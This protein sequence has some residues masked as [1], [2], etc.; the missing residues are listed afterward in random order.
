MSAALSIHDAGPPPPCPAP[1]NLVQHVLAAGRS[2]PDKPALEILSPTHATTLTHGELAR[3]VL[4][5]AGGLQALG[6][7]LGLEGG[8]RILLRIGNHVEFPLVFLGAIA[9]GFVPVPTPAQLT[10]PEVAALCRA[11]DPALTVFGPGCDLLDD[12]PCPVLP[13]ERTAELQ[14]H[15]PVAPVMGDPERPAY[16]IST[17]GTAGRPRLLAHAHR[18]VW[19]R[20]MMWQGWYGL[21]PGDRMFHAGGFNWTYTLGTGLMDPWAV[22]ATAV[23]PAPGLDRVA[24]RRLLKEAQATILAATP[25]VYRQLLDG[26]TRLPLPTLRHGLTAGEKMPPRLARR[27]QEAT[28][29]PLYEA[30]GMSECST[31]VSAHPGRPA[32]EGAIGWPQPGRRVAVLGADRR[33]VPRGTSGILAVSTRDPGLMLGYLDGPESAP[34]IPE[35]MLVPDP[36]TGGRW[37]L[38]G[39]MVEMAEDG[40]ITYLGRQDDMLNAGGFRVSPLEV[41]A[42]LNA[43]PAIRASAAVAVEVRPDVFV[44]GA[45]YESDTE[46][47]EAELAAHCAARLARYKQP[48]LFRRVAALPRNANG[49]I[50]RKALRGR[51][52][53]TPSGGGHDTA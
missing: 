27:W 49:K 43:H 13:P 17:S 53:P 52:F 5:T 35:D 7:R 18:A 11:L 39:D 42:V 4:G 26:V 2:C 12:L 6:A 38:T 24:L 9:A 34:A 31:F 29:T 46:P 50:A 21:G 3:A 22:G 40:A 25:G 32:P 20:R 41:E 14:R 44:I 37:F 19:A 28:G 16:V 30:L 33:P 1:F 23:I 15:D 48:R 51:L 47:D 36:E 45:F 8:A 10:A